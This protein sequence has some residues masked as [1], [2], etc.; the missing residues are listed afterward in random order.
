MLLQLPA[1]EHFEHCLNTERAA[2]IRHW[3]VRTVDEKLYKVWFAIRQYSMRNY[4]FTWKV[5]FKV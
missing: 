1:G 5:N 2:D 3:N 4:M